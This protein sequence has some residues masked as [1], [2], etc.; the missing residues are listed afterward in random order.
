MNAA[1]TR[2]WRHPN[3]MDPV[4]TLNPGSRPSSGMSSCITHIVRATMPALTAMQAQ[5][6]FAQYRCCLLMARGRRSNVLSSLAVR[7]VLIRPE[8]QRY[9]SSAEHTGKNVGV[10]E[11]LGMPAETAPRLS[12]SGFMSGSR[13]VYDRLQ[14]PV[15]SKRTLGFLNS[16]AQRF[17]P[18][19]LVRSQAASPELS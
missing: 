19:F 12:R 7:Q 3:Y 8:H 2:Y 14:K 16:G 15:E 5:A 13:T 4:C 10:W 6:L 17:S 18:Y 11:P 1:R 9:T